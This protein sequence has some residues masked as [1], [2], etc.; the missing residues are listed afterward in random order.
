MKKFSKNNEIIIVGAGIAGLAAAKRLNDAGMKVTVLEARDRIGGRIETRDF[1]GIPIDLGASWIHG[2]VNNPLAKFAQQAHIHLMETDIIH[3]VLL[4]DDNYRPLPIQSSEIIENTFQEVLDAANL[5]AKKSAR[6]LSLLDAIK[7]LAPEKMQDSL[8]CWRMMFYSNYTGAPLNHLSA[9]STDQEVMLEG[10]HQLVVGGYQKIL[11]QLLGN[12]EI[13]F[14]AVVKKIN[15]EKNKVELFSSLGKHEADAVIMTVPLSILKEESID[16][17]PKL[18]PRKITALNNLGMGLLNKV[19][20]EFPDVFWPE[21]YQIIG[22]CTRNYQFAPNFQNFYCYY[23]K[24][25]LIALPGATI[26]ENLEKLTDQEIIE[27]AMQLLRH[28]FG[29]AIPNPSKSMITRWQQQRFS[30]GSYSYIAVGGSGD[31]YCAMAEPVAD[32]LFFAGEATHA[33]FFATVH[34]AYISGIREAER[35]LGLKQ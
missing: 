16:F 24:P 11:Q 13:S 10:G 26:A 28:M 29:N 25:I 15:Y 33:E 12:Y 35:I 5:Y 14:N 34:G 32:R 21:D 19:I 18:S 30:Q 20:L 6:D 1:Y 9:R 22:Y 31:D 4:F 7:K 27:M 17:F 23:K 2:V 8:F 3:N